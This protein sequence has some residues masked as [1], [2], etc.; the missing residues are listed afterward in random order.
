[1]IKKILNLNNHVS[2]S[3][4]SAAF[5]ITAAG[6]VSRVLGLFRDRLLA[7]TFGAGDTL[8]VYYAAFRVP[9]LI[10]NLLIVG[11]LSSAFIPVFTA[12]ISNEKEGEA[13]ELANGIMNLAFYF[14]ILL[15]LIFALFTPF[16]MHIITPGFDELKMA[17]VII[18]TRVMFLSPLLLGVSG[19]L[20]GVLT[21]YKRFLTYSLA[22]IFYNAG[23]IFGILVFVR[24]MGPIGL[25]WGVVFGAVLHF[26]SQ[27]IFVRHLGFKH[28][29][30][31]LSPYS[32][33]DVQ[34]VFHLMIPRAMGIAVN[35]INLFV[36]TIFASLLASGSLAV[37]NFAQN[38]QSLPLGL[39]GI[40]FA[41][42][43]FPTLSSLFS[44]NK[45]EEFVAAFSETFRQIIFFVIPISVFMLL[46]RAQ[47]VRVVLGAGKFDWEDTTLT[48]TCL[49][50]FSLSLFAQSV[51][52]LLARAFYAMHN[53][54]TPFY[55]ALVSEAVNI[56]A[57]VIL[58]GR[59]HVLSLAIA[60]SLSALVQMFLL[61]FA[62]RMEFENLDDRRI[63][64]SMT[65]VIQATFFAGLTVQLFKYIVS[66]MVDLNTFLG[67]FTQLTI[68]SVAGISVF[69]LV[70]HLMKMEE[71]LDFKRIITGKLFR[72][73]KV[74]LEEDISEVSGI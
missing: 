29:W 52:P 72:I 47:I 4:T 14:I 53:T 61:L 27:Y 30:T 54:K 69:I 63:I 45:N 50:I 67:I 73:K 22:P 43:V 64:A 2:G 44:K 33:R 6:L 20:G 26:S 55:I 66:G 57:V 41:M 3:I 39:I 18:F 68:S 51:T 62:L 10:Y 42:A 65:K 24:L 8:D 36:I 15:S 37:F 11:A 56:L 19:I 58:M 9:D 17:Q 32:N 28:S 31:W 38:L 49:G 48:F 5:L 74:T 16:I 23:I 25:A 71:Y 46:L 60:F 13:W 40:S 12:L 1:M 21:S 70:A 59:Y 7:S 35:Q 34:K